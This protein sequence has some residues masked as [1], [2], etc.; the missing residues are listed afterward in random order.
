MKFSSL[1]IDFDNAKILTHYP[2][3]IEYKRIVVDDMS[4]AYCPNQKQISFA[5][6]SLNSKS[7]QQQNDMP[8]CCTQIRP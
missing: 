6:D 8:F 4:V 3:Q 5:N 7:R 1:V 2:K